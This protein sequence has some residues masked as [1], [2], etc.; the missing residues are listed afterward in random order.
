MLTV[1]LPGYSPKNK[2][3]ADEIVEKADLPDQVIV[4]EW[5]HWETNK[6]MDIQDEVLNVLDL[7]GDQKVN[8]IAKSV[9]TRVLMLVIPKI[10]EQINKVVLCGIPGEPVDYGDSLNKLDPKNIMVFQNARDPF[11]KY[12]AIKDRMN[13]IN[14]KIKVI[15]KDAGT[16]HYPYYS[17][18]HDFLT[19]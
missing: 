3:W 9:G 19:L 11:M 2:M 17:D 6:R 13:K 18:F 12:A 15:E 8:F 16:H 4:Y 14:K 10:N 5:K 1:I 7:V